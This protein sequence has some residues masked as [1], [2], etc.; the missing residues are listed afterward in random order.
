ME[1]FTDLLPTVNTSNLEL[2][3]QE[4]MTKHKT[5]MKLNPNFPFSHFN[6]FKLDHG[7]E[8]HLKV[9]IDVLFITM[10]YKVITTFF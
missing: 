8:E 6:S 9:E 7:I 1:P 2:I 4:T 10:I 3:T 5:K